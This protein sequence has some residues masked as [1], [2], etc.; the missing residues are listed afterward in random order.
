MTYDYRQYE[1]QNVDIGKYGGTKEY[2]TNKNYPNIF[3]KE[4][5]GCVDGTKG[6]EFNFSEQNEPINETSTL[7]GTSIKITQTKWYKSMLLNDFEDGYYELFIK[8]ENQN[9]NAYWMSS[10]CVHSDPECAVFDIRRIE[11][12]NIDASPLYNSF[13]NENSRAFAFRPVITLNSNVQIDTVNSGDGST[14][15]QAYV[16]K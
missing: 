16:I 2:T 9:Y 13:G 12:G 4:K 15:E 8:N 14:A 10:R 7:A 6:T 1:N 11:S 3:V 5:T